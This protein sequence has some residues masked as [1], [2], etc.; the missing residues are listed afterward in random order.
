MPLVHIC[1]CEDMDYCISED[2]IITLITIIIQKNT[3]I[4][5]G[6]KKN[7]KIHHTEGKV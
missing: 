1:C 2:A 4:H 5:T 6:G 3:L 7:H